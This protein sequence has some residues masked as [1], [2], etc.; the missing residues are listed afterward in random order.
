MKGR[1][2]VPALGEFILGFKNGSHRES[3]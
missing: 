1:S 2:E 3:L